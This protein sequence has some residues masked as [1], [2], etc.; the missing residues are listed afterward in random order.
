MADGATIAIEGVRLR[1]EV[2]VVAGDGDTLDRLY[3]CRD[4][5]GRDPGAPEAL[6]YGRFLRTH[7]T[8]PIRRGD[9]IRLATWDEVREARTTAAPL[10]YPYRLAIVDGDRYCVGCAHL[11]SGDATRIEGWPQCA[12]RCHEALAIQCEL[13]RERRLTLQ[14]R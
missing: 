6:I 11:L 10:A 3:L 13:D 7:N 12:C 1:D 9:I 14:E 8:C 5:A 2:V 4:G